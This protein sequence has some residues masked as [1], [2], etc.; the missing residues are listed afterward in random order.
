MPAMSSRWKIVL[1][2]AALVL[3]P[4]AAAVRAAAESDTY[5]QLDALMER[6]DADGD[7]RIDI[8][9]F[10]RVLDQMCACAAT[11]GLQ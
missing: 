4:G 9:E 2:L 10:T 3:I 8:T 1:P 11:Q 5:K 6:F 7:G